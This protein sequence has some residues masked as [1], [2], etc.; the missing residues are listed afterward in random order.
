M[1]GNVSP[2]CP[3]HIFLAA[4]RN[5]PEA[6]CSTPDP[7]PTHSQEENGIITYHESQQTLTLIPRVLCSPSTASSPSPLRM[8]SPESSQNRHHNV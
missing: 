5:N 1:C 6:G 2:E 7:H 8:N 3:G 4:C